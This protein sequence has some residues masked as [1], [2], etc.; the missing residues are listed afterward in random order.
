MVI[1]ASAVVEFLLDASRFPRIEGV[2]AGGQVH[3]PHLIDLEVLNALRAAVH[4][5]FLPQSRAEDVLD[6]FF[7]LPI[8]RH[9]HVG[10]MRRIWDLRHNITAY[11]AA[12]VALAES[13]SVPLLTRDRRLAQSSGHAA[14]V[15]YID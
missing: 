15:E 13:L 7:A 5:G 10:L 11:D 12:Y 1:D 8:E 4:R 9:A 2:L 3:A 14:R 6:D